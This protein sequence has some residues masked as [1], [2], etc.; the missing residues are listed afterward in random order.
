MPS[1]FSV[2]SV[3]PCLTAIFHYILN[4]YWDLL[5]LFL[6]INVCLLFYIA[7]LLNFLNI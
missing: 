2:L 4:Q 6:R 3:T 5:H 7:L 1:I